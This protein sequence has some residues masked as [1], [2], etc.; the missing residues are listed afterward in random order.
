MQ[1]QVRTVNEAQLCSRVGRSL[2]LGGT[3]VSLHKT[4]TVESTRPTS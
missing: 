1:G 4:S 2:L 3:A